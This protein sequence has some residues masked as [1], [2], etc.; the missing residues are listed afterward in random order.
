MTKAVLV[1]LATLAQA[2]AVSV[3]LEWDPNTEPDIDHYTIKWGFVQGQE[4]HNIDVGKTTTYTVSEPWPIGGTVYFVLTATNAI[5]L[6]SGPSNE[7]FYT[8]TPWNPN[9]PGHLRITGVTK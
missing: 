7:V 9:A 3:T 2:V 8:I 1:L 4:D 5:G 6:E